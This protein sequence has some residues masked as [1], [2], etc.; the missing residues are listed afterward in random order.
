M[1]KFT[2]EA[3]MKERWVPH[4]LSML[5]YMEQLGS[6]G[7]SRLVSFYA[8]GDGDFRPKF[9]FGIDFERVPPSKEEDGDRI[10]DAG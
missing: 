8:D 7:G 2:I 1:M 10:Y 4:F 9:S 3:E 6:L 5:K